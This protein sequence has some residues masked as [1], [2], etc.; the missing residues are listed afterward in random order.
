MKR[1]VKRTLQ[2][3]A[4][5]LGPHTRSHR[6]PQL[7][8]LMYHRVLPSDDARALRE[9]PG[10][11]VTPDTF[12]NHLNIIKQYTDIIHLSE[13]LTLRSTGAEVPAK[14]CAITFDDGWADNYEFAFPVLKELQVP[15]TIFLVSHMIGTR[16]MFWPE[17]L[18]RILTAVAEASPGDWSHPSLA[19]IRDARTVYRFGALAPTAEELAD[20]IAHAK[21]LPDEEIHRRLDRVEDELELP[22]GGAAPSLLN[23]E[24]MAEMSRS[25]LVEAGSH[26]CQHIRL[27]ADTEDGLLQHEIVAS[28]RHIEEQTGRPVK[29][30]C[31]PNGDYSPKALALVRGHYEGAVT[32]KPGWN[33]AG[34]DPHL[35]HRIGIHEDV[36]RDRT[37]FL[38]RISGWM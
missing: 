4:A 35:L 37:A 8:I 18:A 11:V 2:Y 6:I 20:L 16:R 23:W 12:T 32:T 7:L 34:T 3:V 31:F 15:A 9:E 17:R 14:A 36:S 38:A 5:G 33:S 27:N 22:V 25:G 13:W 29:T 10:M 21:A 24:Q 19:W 30:F 28:K 1:T 26:T